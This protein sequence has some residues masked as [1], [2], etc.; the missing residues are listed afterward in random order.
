MTS[1]IVHPEKEIHINQTDH[2][3]K[4]KAHQTLLFFFG[5][6]DLFVRVPIK[7]Q[8]IFKSVRNPSF[9]NLTLVAPN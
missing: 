2:L 8:L 3:N 7:S 6:F 1:T 4:T 9:K 5:L